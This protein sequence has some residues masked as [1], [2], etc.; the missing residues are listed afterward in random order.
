MPEATQQEIRTLCKEILEVD[1]LANVEIQDL[2]HCLQPDSLLERFAYRKQAGVHANSKE[3]IKLKGSKGQIDHSAMADKVKI[4]N[5]FIKFKCLHYSVT[6]SNGTVDIIVE[7]KVANEFTFGYRT[8]DDTAKAPKDYQHV[9][10]VV[11]MRKQEKELKISIPIVDDEEW[12][13]DLDFFVELY[14]AQ[15]Q[16]K[17]EG[18]DTICKVTILDEDFPGTIGFEK[19]EIMVQ[20]GQD[21]V[22]IGIIRSD[23]SDGTIHCMFKTEQLTE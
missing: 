21:H 5:E 19:T 20:K 22:D 4:S 15:T 11:T 8:V 10:Q 2:L 23:G 14:D 12:E 13:P 17:L 1:N 16:Q 3:F 18:D 9:D 7:K 6:E